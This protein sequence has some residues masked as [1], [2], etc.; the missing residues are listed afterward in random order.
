DVHVLGPP[1][2]RQTDTIRKQRSSDPDEFWQLAPKR[3]NDALAIGG[4]GNLLFP[5]AKYRLR[6][7][8]LLE[9]R[10]LQER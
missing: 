6:S 7:K 2:L 4:E 9:H 8:P 3:L 5:D 1:T 10:W